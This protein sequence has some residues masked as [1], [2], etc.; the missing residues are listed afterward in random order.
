MAMCHT[1]PLR[2]FDRRPHPAVGRARATACPHVTNTSRSDRRQFTWCERPCQ[3]GHRESGR[4][5]ARSQTPQPFCT[6]GFSVNARTTLKAGLVGTL[7]AAAAFALGG[8]AAEAHG[9]L[10]VVNVPC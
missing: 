8:S 9:G 1:Y 5:A 2:A 4:L 6:R 3:P 10:P 7:A